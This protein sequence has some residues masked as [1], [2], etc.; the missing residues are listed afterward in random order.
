M[1]GISAGDELT[2]SDWIAFAICSIKLLI[3]TDQYGTSTHN[4]AC[5]V[6]QVSYFGETVD[7]LIKIQNNTNSLF[8]L[9][10]QST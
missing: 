6:G 10:Q 9:L 3:F 7:R 8:S 4:L 2:T 1:T 5:H